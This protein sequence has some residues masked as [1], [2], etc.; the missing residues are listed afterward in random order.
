M[1]F[2]IET[3]IEV[4]I[5]IPIAALDGDEADYSATTEPCAMH[6][7]FA[8]F[9]DEHMLVVAPH[10]PAC[11][12]QANDFIV[13]WFRAET[14]RPAQHLAGRVEF[15]NFTDFMKFAVA[16]GWTNCFHGNFGF[17]VTI[18]L[19]DLGCFPSLWV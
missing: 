18:K 14:T 8:G 12:N 7:G 5:G 4:E 1:R 17:V 16:D 13:V 2:G 6:D 11:F 10:F 3:G 9:L 15:M 19:D